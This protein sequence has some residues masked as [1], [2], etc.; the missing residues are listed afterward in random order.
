MD[1]RASIQDCNDKFNLVLV[2]DDDVGK[3]SILT[4][5]SMNT[6]KSDQKITK[7]IECYRKEFI[8]DDKVFLFKLWDTPSHEK[9]QLSR[10]FYQKAD[11]ILIVSSITSRE[12]FNSITKWVNSLSEIIDTKSIKMAL[13]SNKVDLEEERQVGLD[14]IRQ[15][16]E[17]MEVQYYE[18]SACT[19]YGIEDSFEDIF[20]R[21]IDSV[22]NKGEGHD[23]NEDEEND[24]DAGSCRCFRSC[25]II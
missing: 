3:T 25:S 18:V 11:C 2:G 12:S 9:N 15:K 5:L 1:Q 13:I 8:S 23:G 20:K 22:Y 19:G 24:N 14:E 4:R 6:F 16:A 21:V 7:N 10:T 17:E